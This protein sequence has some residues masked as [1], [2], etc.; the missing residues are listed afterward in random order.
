MASLY[1]ALALIG[2]FA[3]FVCFFTILTGRRMT[4]IRQ[5]MAETIT[6]RRS[7]QYITNETEMPQK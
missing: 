3:I 2:I 5:R 4:L 7:A 1:G 6:L